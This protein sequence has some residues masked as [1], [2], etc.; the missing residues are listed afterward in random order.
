MRSRV[1]VSMIVRFISDT[2]IL[3]RS[4]DMKEIRDL[5]MRVAI[6]RVAK[7]SFLEFYSVKQLCSAMFNMSFLPVLNK[8]IKGQGIMYRLMIFCRKVA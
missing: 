7:H 8:Y 3:V 6:Q 1:G 2:N 4:P 5:H